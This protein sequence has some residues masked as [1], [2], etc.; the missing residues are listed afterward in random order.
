MRQNSTL[1][2]TSRVDCLEESPRPPRGPPRSRA[3]PGVG[4]PRRRSPAPGPAENASTGRRGRRSPTKTIRSAGTSSASPE[5]RCRAARPS[6]VDRLRHEER[7]ACG[8]GHRRDGAR[9]GCG[10]PRGSRPRTPPDGATTPISRTP[11]A[12]PSSTA[13]TP[14]HQPKPSSTT[15]RRST[16][17]TPAAPRRSS[18]VVV[19]ARSL[20]GSSGS[21]S[22]LPVARTISS[23]ADKVLHA[24]QGCPAGS[25]PGSARGPPRRSRG[26]A[27]TRCETVRA[28]RSRAR[29][30]ARRRPRTA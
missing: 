6:S 7:E 15:S 28:R 20:P 11:A 23:A 14:G 26:S 8:S 17:W 21:T 2:T 4:R 12:T 13:L 30:R 10:S 27:A 19:T 29:L 1:M 18:S 16:P 24:R 3:P 9:A 25:R 22:S 5:R